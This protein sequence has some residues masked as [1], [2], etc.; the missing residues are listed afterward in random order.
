MISPNLH[1]IEPLGICSPFC[2]WQF[3]LPFWWWSFDHFLI[4]N[5][6][7]TCVLLLKASVWFVGHHP[8]PTRITQA[9]IYLEM[10][11]VCCGCGWAPLSKHIPFSVLSIVVK[12][13]S[14]PSLHHFGLSLIA[15]PTHHHTPFQPQTKNPKKPPPPPRPP[16]QEMKH[17][18]TS[19]AIPAMVLAL[20]VCCLTAIFA[21]P[22][23][24]GA[25][26]TQLA[27]F[28][29]STNNVP[30]GGFSDLLAVVLAVAAILTF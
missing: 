17:F 26:G 24:Q 23:N 3:W 11:A 4:F 1:V 8:I 10:R 20:I 16:Q 18:L 15:I 14:R 22:G 7:V 21:L 6:I 25:A 29:G 2:Q 28:E 30:T 5:L 9:A 19:T 13:K 27:V 12:I